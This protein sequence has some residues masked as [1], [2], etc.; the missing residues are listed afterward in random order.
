MRLEGLIGLRRW[1]QVL[2]HIQSGRVKQGWDPLEADLALWRDTTLVALSRQL[3]RDA[4]LPPALRSAMASLQAARTRKA[5]PRPGHAAQPGQAAT[6]PL[7]AD[8]AGARACTAAGPGPVGAAAEAP[9]AD[10]E[11]SAPAQPGPASVQP[12]AGA[13]L[14]ASSTGVLLAAAGAAAPDAD[15]DAAVELPAPHALAAALAELP[16]DVQACRALQCLRACV[17]DAGLC[18]SLS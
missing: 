18:G 13:S 8:A 12:G 7:A 16:V 9:A 4:P 15:G 1:W 11:A 10:A 5:S 17:P 3:G 6:A 2:A 14:R